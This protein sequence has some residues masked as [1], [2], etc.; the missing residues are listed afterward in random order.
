MGPGLARSFRERYPGTRE[1]YRH[2]LRAGHLALGGPCLVRVG[3][4]EILLFPTK[5]DWR[6]PSRI[7]DIDAGLR[8]V[9]R[10]HRRLGIE[11]LALPALGCRLGGLPW[12][13]ARPLVEERLGDASGLLVELYEPLPPLP[14]P[15]AARGH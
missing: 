15:A 9:A 10:Q 2:P 8:W 14:Q 12:E 5:R 11:S 6:E 13:E 1:A 4:R 3:W 7:E